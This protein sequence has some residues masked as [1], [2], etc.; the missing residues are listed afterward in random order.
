QRLDIPAGPQH[1]D[2]AQALEYVRSRHSD[3][4]GDFGRSARQQSVLI[5]LKK[6]LNDTTLLDKLPDL[7]AD[8]QGSVLT[9]LTLGQIVSLANFAKGLQP[10][11]FHQYVL[12]IP[13]YGT[14]GTVEGKSVVLPN[15]AAINQA[16]H[17][18]FP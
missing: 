5:A 2:G 13:N 6:K 15:W 3:L 8:L 7:A 14:Y 17:Q 9:S 18:I 10:T 16:L 4:L 11:D 12:G 1:L